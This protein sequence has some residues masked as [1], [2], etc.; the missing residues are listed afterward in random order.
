M[1]RAA[2]SI[3]AIFISCLLMASCFF[4]PPLSMDDTLL[5]ALSALENK[6]Q[7][8]FYALFLP[9]VLDKLELD[10]ELDLESQFLLIAENYSGPLKEF[11]LQSYSQKTNIGVTNVRLSIECLYEVTTE[12]SFY[13][14]SLVYY[15]LKEGSAGLASFYLTPQIKGQGV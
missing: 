15:E 14:V 5:D 2:L 11:Q 4:P 13:S 8:A 7:E 9:E 12:T 3:G 10:L 1:K 6:D